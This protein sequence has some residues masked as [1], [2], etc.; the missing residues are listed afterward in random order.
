LAAA[1]VALLAAELAYS[2]PASVS[3]AE[4]LNRVAKQEIK[5]AK[6]LNARE[7]N[8]L[9]PEGEVIGIRYSNSDK[10]LRVDMSD[11]EE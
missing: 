3:L 1:F 7:R 8:I 10:C 6:S 2:L 5:N 11:Q 4:Y 9:R